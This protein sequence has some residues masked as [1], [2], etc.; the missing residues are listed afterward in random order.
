MKQIDSK[1]IRRSMKAFFI[2]EDWGYENT[3]TKVEVFEKENELEV[4]IETHCPGI[5]IGRMGRTIDA[6]KEWL[7]KE[8]EKVIK[9]NLQENLMWCDLY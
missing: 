1:K 7:E 3:I 8:E 2:K 9:I 4:L 5:L 6:L